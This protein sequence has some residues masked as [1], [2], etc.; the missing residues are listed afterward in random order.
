MVFFQ[1]FN[2][3]E[4]LGPGLDPVQAQAMPRPG[5]RPSKILE[6]WKNTIKIRNYWKLLDYIGKLKVFQYFSSK[7][8]EKLLFFMVF[9]LARPRPGPD[10]PN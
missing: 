8:L 5:P 10:S 9:H 7:K 1:F 6:N 3:L 4:G 2:I